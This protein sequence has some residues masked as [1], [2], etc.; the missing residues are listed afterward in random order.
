V[1]VRG[2]ADPSFDQF[3]V[4][5]TAVG[6]SGTGAA[7]STK[8]GELGLMFLTAANPN[9]NTE[10]VTA[11]PPSFTIESPIAPTTQ[12]IVQGVAGLLLGPAGTST[13]TANINGTASPVSWQTGTVTVF[14]A[15]P[16]L[17]SQPIVNASLDL[18]LLNP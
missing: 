9:P 8:N 12:A 15:T 5:Q 16:T 2:A 4:S 1:E 18:I 6:M 17:V 7:V 3:R 14:A 10:S 11:V 13:M